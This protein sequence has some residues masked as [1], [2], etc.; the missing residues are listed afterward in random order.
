[1][2]STFEVSLVLAAAARAERDR[3][4]SSTPSVL[5]SAPRTERDR[6]AAGDFTQVKFRAS[7]R[8]HLP[9]HDTRAQ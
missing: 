1:M 7:P 8:T 2:A 5:I 9:S 3:L 6:I 4:A